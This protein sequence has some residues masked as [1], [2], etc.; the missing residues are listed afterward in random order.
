MYTYDTVTDVVSGN[1]HLLEASAPELQVPL[2]RMDV[3]L[4]TGEGRV[5]GAILNR[6]TGE[7]RL[8]ASAA[9]DGSTLR[10]QMTA[11][12]ATRQSEM[13]WLV[14]SAVGPRF[15]GHWRNEDGETVGPKLKLVR[16]VES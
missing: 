15:E 3:R 2:H 16:A 5:R 6:N 13:P 9:F 4:S 1:W 8:L 12:P 7:E 14:M 10:L 11:P